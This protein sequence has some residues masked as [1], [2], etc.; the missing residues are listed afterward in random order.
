M[1]AFQVLLLGRILTAEE[2]KKIGLVT[3]VLEGLQKY[4]SCTSDEAIFLTP[5]DLFFL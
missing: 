4:K 3:E 5:Q 1:L 2:A